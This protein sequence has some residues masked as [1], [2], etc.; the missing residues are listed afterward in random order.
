MKKI[1][2]FQNNNIDLICSGEILLRLS[3]V[4]NELLIQGTLFEKNLG[5]AE[6]NV[7]AGV[8]SLGIKSTLITKLPNNDLGKYAKRIINSNGINSDFII[9]DNSIYK[10]LAIYF[11]E[12]GAFPRKPNVIYDRYNSSFQSLTIDEINKDLY[13]KCNIFHTSGISLGLCHN[14]NLLTKKLIKNFKEKG[15]LISFDVNFR[16]NL[17]GNEENAKLEIEKILPFV[18]ILFAS[19]ETFRKMFKKTGNL[20]DIIKSFAEEYNISIIASTQRKVNSPKSHNFTSII[21][22]KKEKKFYSEKP[23]ENIEVIDR[24]GSGDAYVA[25]VLY[26]ILKYNDTEMALKYGNAFSVV[27]NT[28]LGDNN[29]V[30]NDLIQEIINNHNTE[31]TCEMNR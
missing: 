11:Y 3:P 19:E 6:F 26:G 2:N 24:I 4:N 12:Y 14:S 30:N 5:G 10:R 23:Y 13:D 27:K 31:N 1:F 22:N 20:N 7:A 16:K 17:W 15:G 9:N 18:D 8:S 29:C 25:G 28:I 21:Y